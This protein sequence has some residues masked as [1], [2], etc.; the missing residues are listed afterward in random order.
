MPRLDRPGGEAVEAGRT[1]LG[2]L[3]GAD[4]VGTGTDVLAQHGHD[5]SFHPEARPDLVVWPR[6]VEEAAGIVRIALE[7]RLPLVPFGAGTSLEGHVAAL[8]GGITS[9]C[10]RWMRSLRRQLEDLDVDRPGRRHP[11]P[12]D[13]RAAPRGRVLL[14]R[15]RRRRHDR[16]HGRHGRVRHARPCATARCARTSSRSTVVHGRRRDRPDRARAPASP[17][18]ATTS[19]ACSIGSEGTLGL[20]CEVTLRLHPMPE[21]I[22]AAS[23]RSSIARAARSTP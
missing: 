19:R 13:A 1:A 20:I 2:E 21:A 6:S 5:E 12:L 22:V 17:R 14:G 3:L 9:T 23:A 4:R 15:S 8:A 11:S 10:A 7:H 18:P 16:R